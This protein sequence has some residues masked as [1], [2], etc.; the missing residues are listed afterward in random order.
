M[1]KTD[2]GEVSDGDRRGMRDGAVVQ[3]QPVQ[4]PDSGKL[5]SDFFLCGECGGGDHQADHAI[6]GKGPLTYSWLRGAS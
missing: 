6:R 4:R 3:M 1:H 5:I 2:F